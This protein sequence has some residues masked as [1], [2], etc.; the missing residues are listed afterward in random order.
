MKFPPHVLNGAKV[1]KET[2]SDYYIGY[3]KQQLHNQNVDATGQGTKQFDYE[4]KVNY[5]HLNSSSASNFSTYLENYNKQLDQLGSAAND[6]KAFTTYFDPYHAGRMTLS[7]LKNYGV[8]D[9]VK[10]LIDSGAFKFQ[11]TVDST[12]A[13][14][15][16][17][18]NKLARFTNRHAALTHIYTQLW[19]HNKIRGEYVDGVLSYVT[20]RQ[21]DNF[22]EGRFDAT[23]FNENSVSEFRQMFGADSNKAFPDLMKTLKVVFSDNYSNAIAFNNAQHRDVAFKTMDEILTKGNYKFDVEFKLSKSVVA[24]KIGFMR[25]PIYIIQSILNLSLL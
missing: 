16:S 9:H 2:L 10:K 4:P 13:I 22:P 18:T 23:K 3:F 17:A 21:G 7:I 6:K 12:G 1:T 5:Y 8:L 14:I 20:Y 15:E 11:D 25:L 24:C 19:I